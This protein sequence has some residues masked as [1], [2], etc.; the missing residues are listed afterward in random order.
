MA[1]RPDKIDKMVYSETLA[2]R[3]LYRKACER[4]GQEPRELTPVTI[5]QRSVQ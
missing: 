3:K 2:I 1:E 4:L 5:M